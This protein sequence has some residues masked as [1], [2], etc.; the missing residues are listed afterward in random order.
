MYALVALF[1]SLLTYATA[2]NVTYD[3]NVGWVDNVNL[4][5]QYPRRAIGINGV[6]PPPVINI[7][8]SDSFTINF[9]NTFNDGRAT[10]LHSHG[11]FFNNTGYFDG[12]AS[13]TQC[14]IPDG[15]SIAYQPLNSP[16]SPAGRQAQWG[17]FWTHGH[18]DGQYVDGLRTPAIIH[19]DNEP[20]KYD[21][22]FTIILA[23]WYHREHHDLIVNE[24]LNVKNPTGAEPIPDSG[25]VYFAHTAKGAN[26]EYL[27]GYN[28][29]A[30]LSFEPGKTYRLRLI[31]MAA[32][33]MFHF[34]I[35]GHNMSIIEADGVDM[36]PFPVDTV[37]LSVAQRYSVL[38]TA[39]NDTS[40]NWPIHFNLDPSMYDSVPPTLNLNLT[41]TL[42]YKEGNP[43][44]SDRPTIDYDYFD[45]TALV[46]VIVEPQLNA[47]VT[48]V[49][50]FDFTTYSDGKNYAAFN[51]TS[52]VSALTPTLFTAMSMPT[53]E[54]SLAQV[55][56]P[57]SNAVVVDH[58]KA[59][60]IEIINLDKGNHPFHLHG[61]H[62]QVVHKSQDI[63]SDDPE[64]NPPR[65]EGQANPMR[66]DTVL[67]PA[68]G[69]ASL[70]LV[71]DNPGAWFLHCHIDFHLTSGLAMVVIE[72][73]EQ[74]Q[75]NLN[76][77]SYMYQQCQQQGLPY[78]GNAGGLQSLT[79]FG[80]LPAG[81]TPLSPGWTPKA[82]GT[83]VACL[84]TA[85]LGIGTVSW[86][87]FS[88]KDEDDEDD[89]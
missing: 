36:Q 76:V 67:I 63:T 15:G 71:A 39:R 14:P 3:W 26:A 69:S 58:L 32:L 66:R 84:I 35:E 45:D 2:A 38:V 1:C 50:S 44:G 62:F 70:R 42:S 53:N 73:P 12:A 65:K 29:N 40:Q 81:P 10:A 37:S 8:Q 60:E 23:D 59:F 86:Y 18:Y 57:N 27:P 87:G 89:L 6:Y 61:H 49:T 72:A 22:D 78:T 48:F 82:I 74:I 20:H 54:T 52:F 34:W 31:N 30:T 19:A 5:G 17:T 88:S 41:S 9:K 46:P 16:L 13:V 21:D 43:M 4:D 68:G 80:A 25:L 55:Y 56:G 11:M 51:G 75:K 64:L 79:N 24:F 28:E 83:F 77:P 85:L 47:D 7:N 33:S